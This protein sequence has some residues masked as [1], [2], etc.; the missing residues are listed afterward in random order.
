M[1]SVLAQFV[2][3]GSTGNTFQGHHSQPSGLGTTHLDPLELQSVAQSRL[4]SNN[5]LFKDDFNFGAEF[6][7]NSVGSSS[8]PSISTS[9]QRN[10]GAST[11]SENI[12]RNITTSNTKKVMMEAVGELEKLAVGEM[13]MLELLAVGALEMLEVL[14]Q[15]ETQRKKNAAKQK[16]A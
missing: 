1:A 11:I 2:S 9:G 8:R 10:R 16:A 14:V 3:L 12:Q 5:V 4:W 6:R 7:G 15:T 13:E